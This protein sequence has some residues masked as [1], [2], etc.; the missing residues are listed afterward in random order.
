MI[1]IKYCVSNIYVVLTRNILHMSV[2]ANARAHL[3]YCIFQINETIVYILQITI[4][5]TI[6]IIYFISTIIIL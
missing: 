1:I 5:Y 4:Q 6:N 3:Y 2:G